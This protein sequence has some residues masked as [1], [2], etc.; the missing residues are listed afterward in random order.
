MQISAKYSYFTVE[1]WSIPIVLSI[2]RKICK[3]KIV[4]CTVTV[5]KN[6]EKVR[7]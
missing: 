5:K 3:R 1:T 6:S 2:A 4:G 7:I